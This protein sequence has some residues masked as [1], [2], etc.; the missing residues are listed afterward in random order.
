MKFG[1]HL[2]FPEEYK[3][4]PKQKGSSVSR[5]HRSDKEV[6]QNA[7]GGLAREGVYLCG[8]LEDKIEERNS[9]QFHKHSGSLVQSN[10]MTTRL[11]LFH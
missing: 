7:S 5:E 1:L 2:S 6:L 8:K 10:S 9:W 11:Y 4:Q 3:R